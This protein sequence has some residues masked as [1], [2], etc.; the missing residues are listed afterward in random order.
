MDP[1][2]LKDSLYLAKQTI[3]NLQKSNYHSKIWI[4]LSILEL[5]II[6]Y[7]ILRTNNSK[8]EL[9]KEQFKAEALSQEIDFDNIIDSSF[10]AAKLY[11]ELKI[12]YHPDKF[13]DNSEINSLATKLFQEITKNKTNLKR[14]QEL[15]QEAK[16]KLKI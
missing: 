11:D 9:F 16:S 5:G 4:V 10:N 15:R 2:I 14:L 12:K 1:K 8:K 3:I 13:T 6:I 7:L